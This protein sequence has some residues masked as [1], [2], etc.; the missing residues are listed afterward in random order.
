M[1]TTFIQHSIRNVRTASG[2]DMLA[3]L[4]L[5]LAP[6]IL[7]YSTNPAALWNNLI[8]GS[9]VVILAGIRVGERGYRMVWPSWVNFI[10]GLWLIISPYVLSFSTDDR[11]MRNTIALGVIIAILAAWSALSTPTEGTATD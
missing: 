1:A 8:V 7:G 11:A 3:G 9:A 5:I 10:L 4:W 6:F 2:L